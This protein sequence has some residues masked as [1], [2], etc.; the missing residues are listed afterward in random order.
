MVMVIQMKVM[1]VTID[2][3]ATDSDTSA[4]ELDQQLHQ[5]LKW[6]KW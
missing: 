1:Q 6:Y 2:S 3:G 5:L 4:A